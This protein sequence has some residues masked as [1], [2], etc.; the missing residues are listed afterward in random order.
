LKEGLEDGESIKNKANIVF[1]Y[2]DPIVTP[3]WINTKDNIAPTSKM[4]QTE[5]VS[6]SIATLCWSGEDNKGGSG[7]YSYHVYTWK[8][9]D[10]YSTLLGNTSRNSINFQYEKDV[11]YFFYVTAMDS[12]GN[13]EIKTIIPDINLFEK[14]TG[15]PG[16]TISQDIQMS[17]YPNPPDKEHGVK[18]SLSLPSIKNKKL[19]IYSMDGSLIRT[20][21]F[22]G[23][24]LEVKGL[25][26]GM[27]IFILQL[28]NKNVVSQKVTIQ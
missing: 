10:A 4:S 12:A 9:G 15:T 3:I 26:S 16:L 6:D 17:I 5:I 25:N 1:D 22:K 19:L 13:Q 20:I 28:A 21:L 8:S 18:V 24:E 14:S 2:N 27:Y 23:K 7:I 11:E